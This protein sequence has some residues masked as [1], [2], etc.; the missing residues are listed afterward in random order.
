MVVVSG[1]WLV[2]VGGWWWVM[3]GGGGRPR[4]ATGGHRGQFP[5]TDFGPAAGIY[6]LNAVRTPK[7]T[8]TWGNNI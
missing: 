4:E 1:G 8:L 7:A 6:S 3:A 5:R 2:V